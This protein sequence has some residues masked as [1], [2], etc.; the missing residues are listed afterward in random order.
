MGLFDIQAEIKDGK[1]IIKINIASGPEKP[2]YKKKFGMS[3]KGCFIRNGTAADPMPQKMIDELFA[4]RTR[5]SLG[6]IVS[7]KQDLKFEQLKIYYESAGLNSTSILLLILN[8]LP[9]QINTIMLR[10]YYLTIILPQ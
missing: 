6:R 8:Y 9:N 5:N 3:E 1:N 4:K 10:I 7:R 2:Y